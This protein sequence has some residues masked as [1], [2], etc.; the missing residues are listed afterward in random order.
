MA[1]GQT[2][3]NVVTEDKAKPA[4]KLADFRGNYK[5]NLTRQERAR[6]QC[7]GAD[8]LRSGTITRSPTTGCR[9]SR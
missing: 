1:D 2:W 9:A 8:L 4:E 3:K 5:Y 6:V 7:R